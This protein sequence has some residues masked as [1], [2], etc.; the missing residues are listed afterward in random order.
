M[1][2]KLICVGIEILFL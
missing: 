1:R 2:Y